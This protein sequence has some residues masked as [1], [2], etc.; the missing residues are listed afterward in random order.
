[1]QTSLGR[2]HAL[3][4][5]HAHQANTCTCRLPCLFKARRDMKPLMLESKK[6]ASQN[7]LSMLVPL[8]LL[9]LLPRCW[10][11]H[12]AMCAAGR[13]RESSSE[14][15]SALDRLGLASALHPYLVNLHRAPFLRC[16]ARGTVCCAGVS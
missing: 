8:L 14:G 15:A 4:K 5:P 2:C 13:T 12:A 9:L 1:M 11:E 6:R 10:P 16:S 3:R 7:Q